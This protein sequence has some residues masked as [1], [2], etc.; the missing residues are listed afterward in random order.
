MKKNI[1]LFNIKSNNFVGDIKNTVSAR[2]LH[3]NLKSK[4]DFSA[5]I[6]RFLQ[7]FIE[8]QDYIKVT[9]KVE[10]SKTGQIGIEYFL[11]IDTAKNIAMM[12]R[13]VKGK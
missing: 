13:T 5:W 9:Q 7:G 3:K 4:K 12:Q 10:L 11:T 8:D 1:Q 6:K 2:E